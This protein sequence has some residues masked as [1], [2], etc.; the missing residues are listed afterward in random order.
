[1]EKMKKIGILTHLLPH[2]PWWRLEPDARWA[3][4]ACRARQHR[5]LP[6]SAPPAQAWHA[7]SIALPELRRFHFEKSSTCSDHHPAAERGKGP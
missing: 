4:V 2:H 3:P 5:I 7:R 1:M 6:R